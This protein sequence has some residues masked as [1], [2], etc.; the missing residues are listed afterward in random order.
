MQLTASERGEITGKNMNNKP[1]PPV[2]PGLFSF[3]AQESEN[4]LRAKKNRKKHNR[5]FHLIF[6]I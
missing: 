2:N 1:V 6:P 3:L 4:H 5:R